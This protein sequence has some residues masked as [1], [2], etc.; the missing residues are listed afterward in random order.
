MEL[1]GQDWDFEHGPW[2]SFDSLMLCDEALIGCLEHMFFFFFFRMFFLL[3]IGWFPELD[4]KISGTPDMKLVSNM[5]S[6]GLLR[7][8]A[9]AQRFFFPLGP[10]GLR[11]DHVFFQAGPRWPFWGILQFRTK[12]IWDQYIQSP[13]ISHYIPLNTVSLFSMVEPVNVKLLNSIVWLNQQV[14]KHL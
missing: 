3:N 7:T 13:W 11:G 8:A 1:K 10:H 2:I 4:E 6:P 9:V 14:N 5:L 12:P